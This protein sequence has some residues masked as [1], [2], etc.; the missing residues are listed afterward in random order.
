VLGLAGPGWMRCALSVHPGWPGLS[1]S[2]KVSKALCLV[3]VNQQR[4]ICQCRL[5]PDSICVNLHFAPAQPCD[6]GESHTPA[7]VFSS[8][9]GVGTRERPYYIGSLQ[10]L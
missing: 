8:I 3:C 6:L 2:T 5:E 7:S 9:M 4:C 1:A 10:S